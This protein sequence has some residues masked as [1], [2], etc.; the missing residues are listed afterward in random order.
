MANLEEAVGSGESVVTNYQYEQNNYSDSQF[1]KDSLER[2]PEQEEMM[3]LVADGAYSGKEHHDLASGKNIRL[4]NTNLSDRAVDDIL[5]DFEFNE[6]GTKVLR[7][8]AGTNQNLA[9]IQEGSPNSS[10][11]LSVGSSVQDV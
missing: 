8:S 5:A 4:I 11:Y 9:D 1:L 3:T 6:S 2:T 10:M 7:C